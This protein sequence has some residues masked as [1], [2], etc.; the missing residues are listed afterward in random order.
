MGDSAPTLV[1][2]ELV[3]AHI[4]VF[5]D[6]SGSDFI[7]ISYGSVYLHHDWR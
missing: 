4:L 1:I 6:N 5:E 7:G 2:P 3:L